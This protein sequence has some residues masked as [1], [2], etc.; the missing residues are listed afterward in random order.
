[1]C[2]VSSS[3]FDAEADLFSG[4]MKPA[5]LTHGVAW[6][7]SKGVWTWHL[8][9]WCSDRLG[10]TVLKVEFDDHRGFFQPKKILWFYESSTLIGLAVTQKSKTCLCFQRQVYTQQTE[11]SFKSYTCYV[12]YPEVVWTLGSDLLMWFA[13]T[14][15]S[16]CFSPS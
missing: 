4:L 10:S 3:T 15:A 6:K 1:M 9:S 5:P 8:G 16:D 14:S 13:K 2:R 11:K 7:C 12:G